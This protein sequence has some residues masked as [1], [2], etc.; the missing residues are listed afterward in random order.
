MVVD[1]IA[2]I[3]SQRKHNDMWNKMSSCIKEE[4]LDEVLEIADDGHRTVTKLR[5]I[6]S[7]TG[8]L[9]KLYFIA[10]FR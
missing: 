10:M 9:C 4:W 6:Y 8:V 3:E 5:D 7:H 1:E 2:Q